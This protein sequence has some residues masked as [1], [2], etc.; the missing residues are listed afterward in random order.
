MIKKKDRRLFI[1][2]IFQQNSYVVRQLTKIQQ[3]KNRNTSSNDFQKYSG[4][5]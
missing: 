4:A 3:I 2:K 5:F 1:F